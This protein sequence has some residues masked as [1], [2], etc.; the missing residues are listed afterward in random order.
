MLKM[1]LV[2]A[3][4]I[5]CA[6]MSWAQCPTCPQAA[7]IDQSS[8]GFG[9]TT[10]IIG[11]YDNDGTNDIVVGAYSQPGTG[12]AYIISGATGAV[13]R[14]YNGSSNY[15]QFGY[16]VANIGDIDNCGK[17]DFAVG[18]PTYG[19]DGQNNLNFGRV[20]VYSGSTGNQIGNPIMVND[21]LD[22]GLFQLG[23]SIASAGDWN[24]DGYKDIIIGGP[25]YQ[26]Y[27]QG[28]GWQ[29]MPGHAFIYSYYS[30][31]W[32]RLG[33]ITGEY[34][35]DYF[36]FTVAGAGNV[37]GD[38]YD[39]V[40]IGTPYNHNG[41]AEGGKVY[42]Y[43]GNS[44]TTI[45]GAVTGSHYAGH[46]GQGISGTGDLN[47]DG[48]DD[49]LIG[50]PG[51]AMIQAVSMAS[52][53]VTLFTKTGV[54]L[55][56]FGYS[57]SGS[58]DL[59]GDAIPD[60]IVGAPGTSTPTAYVYSGDANAAGAPVELAK[61][62]GAP[63][64]RFGHSVSGS[65]VSSNP[66]GLE[67]VGAP[68]ETNAYLFKCIYN[69]SYYVSNSGDDV[70]GNGCQTNPYKTIQ[71]GI[72]VAQSGDSVQVIAGTYIGIGNR[73]LNYH[74]K[75]IVLRSMSGADQTII[76]CQYATRGFLF[77]NDESRDS[78]LI[79]FTIQNGY[80]LGQQSGG[81]WVGGGGGVYI[82][83]ASPTIDSCKFITCKDDMNSGGA[84]FMSSGY[85]SASPLIIRCVFDGNMAELYNDT[86]YGQGGA[87]AI[88]NYNTVPVIDSCIFKNN[89]AQISGGAIYISGISGF[90][91]TK[92]L[93]DGNQAGDATHSGQ[94]GV[95]YTD[96][97]LTLERCTFVENT[98][99][100]G[101]VL[102]AYGYGFAYSVDFNHNIVANN[103]QAEAIRCAGS[104][105]SVLFDCNIFWNN[106]SNIAG[107]CDC[108]AMDANTRF[109]DPL[110][111]DA[112]NGN[113]TI[114][115]NSICTPA[116]SPCGQLIGAYT[117]ACSYSLAAGPTLTSPSDGSSTT[118]SSP[119]LDWSDV[120]GA[121]AYE[122]WVD[123]NQNFCSPERVASD[124]EFSTWVVSPGVSDG[125]WY[126][127]VRA[128]AGGVWS[129][130]SSTWSFQKY[131]PHGNPS[132]P[133]L[134]SFDGQ[135]FNMENPLL[136]ACELNGYTQAVTDFYRVNNLVASGDGNVTFQ[137]KEMED[138]ITYLSDFELIS[139][140][141]SPSSYVAVSTEG[142]II[143]FDK[144]ISPKSAVDN[145]GIDRLAEVSYG[146]GN[147]F[148]SNHKGFI[149]L[150]FPYVAGKGL[151]GVAALV[152]PPCPIQRKLN[153]D[154]PSEN[155]PPMV[156]VEF[157]DRNGNWT[158]AAN[159][160]PRENIVQEIVQFNPDV[161]GN[162]EVVT[163]RL[164]WDKSYETDVIYQLE[165][166]DEQ[167]VVKNWEFANAQLS[168]AKSN[169]KISGGFNQ[170]NPLVMTKGDVAQF[171]FN[172][173]SV[174]DGF[175]RDYIIKASGR[176]QPDY[177]VYTNLTPSGFQ[178]YDN[179]PNPFNPSTQ[180]AYDLP[181]ATHVKLV[182]FNTLGQEVRTL[183]DRNQT[184][185]HWVLNWD[186]T[187]NKGQ[188]V[189][190]G[191]YLYKIEA[192]N[193][194]QTKK[195]TLLK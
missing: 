27:F 94:G 49:I 2:M 156:S 119:T 59:N 86:W 174:P 65:L 92:C 24:N 112:A 100:E 114:S 182:V 34:N 133:V 42:V 170:A 109:V 146:D 129:N 30:G 64:S 173:G 194:G 68:L 61:M 175:S 58:Q 7:M 97:P 164:S 45:I 122:V 39:D 157:L 160:P 1:L 76:D 139:V 125:W 171:N 179:Y 53:I 101:A 67:L 96:N 140:D 115:T 4:L 95:I 195:M 17:P 15:D 178:L 48:R 104:D 62:Y 46:L 16:F 28:L 116:N 162:Q 81:G 137:L 168:T 37:N 88:Y 83:E 172:C 136:T 130:W 187:D 186:G 176:Y 188:A 43:A 159:I 166:N 108:S 118:S 38:Q 103:L 150:T 20:Y 98:A 55:S 72:D 128:F 3:S 148:K 63:G 184:A 57:V 190:S 9:S 10:A 117:A 71:K 147:L 107:I 155:T 185:G 85:N 70:T 99:N 169:A 131:T 183:V 29:Y 56:E 126:W 152:K 153:T 106:Y 105:C 87:M 189:A 161:I 77:D 151:I 21:Y 79:G 18:S 93:F 50:E 111:C 32:H 75:A 26:Y 127:R 135:T 90:S 163:I 192:D 74:G 12:H 142:E 123:N 193:F 181:N 36:G 25:G 44:T 60:L 167:P 35:L 78:K 52:G 73:N 47:G 110:F 41:A 180:I 191:I 84:I 23:K 149:T 132:C 144:V 141:H 51:A 8:P 19:N 14:T 165:A 31:S 40:I 158:R 177:A 89:T 82:E 113:Y 154:E 121:T 138:E 145:E 134:Y 11:D 33:I 120:S 13:L 143:S 80:G 69:R 102:Y 54:S 6:A 66:P 91:I 5:L 124:L 22:E